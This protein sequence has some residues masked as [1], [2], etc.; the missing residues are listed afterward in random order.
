[1]KP[2]VVNRRGR[3]TLPSNFFPEIDFCG[4]GRSGSFSAV[5]KRDFEQNMRGS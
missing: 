3:L 2:F 1:V 5:V 4:S